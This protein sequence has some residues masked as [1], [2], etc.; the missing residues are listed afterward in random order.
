MFELKDKVIVLTGATGALG[1]EL[2]L[3]LAKAN[4]KLVILGR[5]EVLLDELKKN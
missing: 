3:S 4:A 1:S 5:N 2:A